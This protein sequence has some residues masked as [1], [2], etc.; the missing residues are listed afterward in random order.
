MVL[1]SLQRFAYNL[2]FFF[3]FYQVLPKVVCGPL[4]ELEHYNWSSSVLLC[5]PY[6]LSFQGHYC[7]H[8][9]PREAW[10]PL[11]CVPGWLGCP[12]PWVSLMDPNVGP[13]HIFVQLLFCNISQCF[14][15]FFFVFVCC[16][17]SLF[18]CTPEEAAYST[19]TSLATCT[20]YPPA[21]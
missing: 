2:L 18:L 10:V 11:V 16:R 19:E 13:G 14:S 4:L 8:I 17:H 15:I 12:H 5:R 1:N 21:L 7:S 20:V 9:S 6:L 3:L